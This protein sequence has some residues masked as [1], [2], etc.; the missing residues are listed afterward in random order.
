MVRGGGR[1]TWLMKRCFAWTTLFQV[2][3][4]GFG[5]S[6]RVQ[7]V[8]LRVSGFESGARGGGAET[9]LRKR[10]LSWTTLPFFK[11]DQYLV[12]ASAE[13][14]AWVMKVGEWDEG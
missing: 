13:D 8:R 1:G 14:P 12:R 9:W 7:S 3:D 10:C 6:F 5:F 2:E 4:L 11:V